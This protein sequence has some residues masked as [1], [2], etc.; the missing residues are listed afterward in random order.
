M[1]EVFDVCVMVLDL[2][3]GMKYEGKVRDTYVTGDM[4]IVVMMD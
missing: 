4:M 2:G 1:F 3:M